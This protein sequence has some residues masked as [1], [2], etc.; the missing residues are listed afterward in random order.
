MPTTARI[1]FSHGNSFPASTY[2]VLF[3]SLRQR[4]FKVDALE[5]FGHDPKYPVT[6][7]WPH[8]VEQLTDF[9]RKNRVQASL[10]FWWATHWV[11]S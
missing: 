6:N 5:K 8:L 10:R 4:G 1:V 2:R 7:N 3:D 9:A 11:A